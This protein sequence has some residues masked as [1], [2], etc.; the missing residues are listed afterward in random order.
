M[1]KGFWQLQKIIALRSLHSKGFSYFT[2]QSP[3]TLVI[4]LERLTQSYLENLIYQ[5]IRSQAV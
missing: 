5:E 1:I 2:R 4:I 3:R